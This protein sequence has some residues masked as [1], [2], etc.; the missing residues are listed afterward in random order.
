MTLDHLY[1]KALRL[2]GIIEE[3][4]LPES[5]RIESLL[6]DHDALAAWLFAYWEGRWRG[7]W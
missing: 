4:T 3:H 2:Q 6:L 5:W 1:E 7:Y